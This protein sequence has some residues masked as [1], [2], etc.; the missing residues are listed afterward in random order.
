MEIRNAI[1]NKARLLIDDHNVLTVWIDL[2]YGGLCQ[3]FGGYAL[4]LP[5]GFTHHNVWG[6]AGHFIYRCLQIAGVEKWE[7]L[8][9]KAIRVKQDHSHVYAIGHI[10]KDDWFCPKD[11]FENLDYKDITK[12]HGK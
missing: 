7:Q 1:I 3:G 12:E 4:Y 6:T 10:I 11:D 2:D 8:S 5:E 9:G